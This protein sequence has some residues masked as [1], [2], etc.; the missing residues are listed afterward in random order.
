MPW[1]QCSQCWKTEALG[2]RGSDSDRGLS[3]MA[4]TESSDFWL[5]PPYPTLQILLWQQFSR[6]V[7][8]DRPKHI[9][10]PFLGVICSPCSRGGDLEPRWE[11]GPRGGGPCLSCSPALAQTFLFWQKAQGAQESPTWPGPAG[12]NPAA[13][14]GGIIQKKK[15]ECSAYGRMF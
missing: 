2:T 9:L 6:E 5:A 15:Y 1:M 14:H 7:S 12:D 10:Q 4:P 8:G 13:E 3:H 11:R